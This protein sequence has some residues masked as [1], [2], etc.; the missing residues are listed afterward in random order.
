MDGQN[1]QRNKIKHPEINT[2]L[3]EILFF[4]KSSSQIIGEKQNGSINGTGKVVIHIEKINS[5]Q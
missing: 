3:Y 5:T 1:D 4:D 2:Y